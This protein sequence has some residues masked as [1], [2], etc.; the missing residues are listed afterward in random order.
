MQKIQKVNTCSLVKTESEPQIILIASSGIVPSSGWKQP[1]LVGWYYVTPPEDGIQDFDFCAMPP[2]GIVM[3]VELPITGEAIIAVSLKKY[4]G[5][6]RPLV[7]VRIHAR[8]NFVEALLDEKSV[9][10]VEYPL[11]NPSQAFDGRP[12]PF[13]SPGPPCDPHS[14]VAACSPFPFPLGP[15]VVWPPRKPD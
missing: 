4:W 11:G 15:I 8:T 1:S 2:T 12:W 13:F 5:D 10:S 9:K 6:G 14:G 3:P 7:G